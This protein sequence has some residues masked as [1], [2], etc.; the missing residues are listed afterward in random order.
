MLSLPNRGEFRSPDK[1][2]GTGCFP[3]SPPA[4][5]RPVRSIIKGWIASAGFDA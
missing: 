1:V 5:R 2:R 3:G 4:I